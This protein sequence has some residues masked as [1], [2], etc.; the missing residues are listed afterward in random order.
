MLR[1]PERVD[2]EEIRVLRQQLE[3]FVSVG[4]PYYPWRRSDVQ[5]FEYTVTEILLQS[6][7]TDVVAGFAPFFLSELPSW[8]HIATTPTADIAELLKPIGLYR[9]RAERLKALASTL[10]TLPEL[11]VTF[12]ELIGLPAI[13]LYIASAVS[14][15]FGGECHP[16]LDTNM[17]RVLKRCFHLK[18]RV[19]IRVDKELRE[20]A[21]KIV[22]GTNCLE[23][24]WAIL[25]IGRLYCTSRSPKHAVC[26][27]RGCCCRSTWPAVDAKGSQAGR[28]L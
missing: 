21:S 10:L 19:D 22:A 5:Y 14:T 1:R 12:R 16:M 4:L 2:T 13:G 9:Q 28:V 7:R 17:A 15:R 23:Y 8:E 26:P 25:D 27:L 20:L 6:T 24:N 11:P 3:E 18:I